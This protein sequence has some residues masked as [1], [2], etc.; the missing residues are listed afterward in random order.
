MLDRNGIDRELYTWA[1]GGL[2]R[3]NWSP[4]YSCVL[5]LAYTNSRHVGVGFSFRVS[6]FVKAFSGDK[7]KY[8][9]EKCD[10]Q[11]RAA[12]YEPVSESVA[13]KFVEFVVGLV[14]AQGGI[15]D[16]AATVFIYCDH[17]F[18]SEVDC[19]NDNDNCYDF[20][21]FLNCCKVKEFSDHSLVGRWMEGT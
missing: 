12:E 1:A 7:D 18:H 20:Q 19:G 16:M 17:K 6:W 11:E 13:L 2:N 8:P 4:T 21:D 14:A 9:S 5:V 3:Q 10:G 15:D